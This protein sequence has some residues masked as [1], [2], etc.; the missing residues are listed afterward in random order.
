MVSVL[1]SRWGVVAVI[2]AGWLNSVPTLAAE[3]GRS[4]PRLGTL[5]ELQV[6]ARQ[7]VP[8]DLMIATLFIEQSDPD[9]AKLANEVNRKLNDTL[10]LAR[11]YPAIKAASS[12]YQTW[13]VYQNN[14]KTLE[15]WRARAELRLESRDFPLLSDVLGKLQSQVQLGGLGFAVSEESRQKAEDSL[16]SQAVQAFRARAELTRQA[17]GANA[18]QIRKL[19]LQGQGDYAPVRPLFAKAM[20][21]E[22]MVGAVATPDV[23]AGNTQVTLTASGIVAIE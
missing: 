23:E 10:K 7:S 2:A 6:S 14:G 17:L 13:P 18:Y 16:V 21:N 1:Q 9:S 8:N 20:M 19:N 4:V 12:S 11:H 15:R 3:S 5:V 22:R